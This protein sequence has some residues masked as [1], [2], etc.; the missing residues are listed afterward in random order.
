MLSDGIDSHIHRHA[1][2]RLCLRPCSGPLCT[3]PTEIQKV[4][5]GVLKFPESSNVLL[6]LLSLAYPARSRQE[7]LLRQQ[8]WTT[9]TCAAHDAAQQYQF[10]QAQKLIAEMFLDAALPETYPHRLVSIAV[11][12]QIPELA[13]ELEATVYTLKHPHRIGFGTT[14]CASLE[15]FALWKY[16]SVRGEEALDDTECVNTVL[17]TCSE[18][19]EE[20]VVQ[21][22]P[23]LEESIGMCL[24]YW[25][26]CHPYCDDVFSN[27]PRSEMKLLCP[28][29]GVVP[30]FSATTGSRRL[31]STL[32]R[33]S[34]KSF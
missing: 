30:R 10:V 21:L 4:G 20:F 9:Y 3:A 11:L 12:R 25:N 2:S 31:H 26:A 6:R 33:L 27:V 8:I 1:N 23:F 15:K 24:I 13:R 32:G 22:A 18:A 19:I 28:D 34:R 17:P 29:V 16:S 5:E 7:M 14:S